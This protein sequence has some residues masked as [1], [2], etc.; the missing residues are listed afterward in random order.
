MKELYSIWI[1]SF[2]DV[3]TNTF[4]GVEDLTRI[5]A[6][7][8]LDTNVA[9]FC[10]FAIPFVLENA[11]LYNWSVTTQTALW[12]FSLVNVYKAPF[13]ACFIPVVS[14]TS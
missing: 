7:E 6:K 4:K 1:E 3:I 10:R 13:E 8:L 11:H 5:E 2:P 9:Y 14:D 12:L